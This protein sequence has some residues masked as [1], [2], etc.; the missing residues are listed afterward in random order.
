MKVGIVDLQKQ[1]VESILAE[2]GDNRTT[3]IK[4]QVDKE[5]CVKWFCST[6]GWLQSMV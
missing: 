1:K 3:A 4:V 6:K 5:E 2:K